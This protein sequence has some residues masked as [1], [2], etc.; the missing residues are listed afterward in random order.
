V[1]PGKEAQRGTQE[2]RYEG[3]GTSRKDNE[4]GKSE[5]IILERSGFKKKEEEFWFQ[6]RQFEIVELVE[7]WVEERSW[8]K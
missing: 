4:D 1:G 7:T 6:V 2:R 8:E 5:G 3:K